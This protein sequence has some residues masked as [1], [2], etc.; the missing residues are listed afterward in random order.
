M[1][2]QCTLYVPGRE[3][4]RFALRGITYLERESEREAQDIGLMIESAPNF[5]LKLATLYISILS[6]C[7]A[8]HFFRYMLLPRL[9]HACVL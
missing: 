3:R 2:A 4:R 8:R 5:L 9:P 6:V 1:R 7:Y